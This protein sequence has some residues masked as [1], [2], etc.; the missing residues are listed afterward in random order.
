MQRRT[1][2]SIALV[3]L[4]TASPILSGLGPP[5]NDDCEAAIPIINGGHA[6][7][8]VGA[9]TDGPAHAQCEFDGQTYHDIWYLYEGLCDGLLEVHT[10]GS[11]YDTDLVGY[12]NDDCGSL[13]L[14]TCND[15]WNDC[16]VQSL[17]RFTVQEGNFYLIRVGGWNDG[18]SGDGLLFI[19]GP[20]PCPPAC[21]ADL[22]GDGVVNVGDLLTMLLAWGANP[23]HPADL[24]GDGAVT[25][26]DL[27]LLLAAWGPC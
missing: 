4:L 22:N 13:Q 17:I 8:T 6:Y 2:C 23:G 19:D 10:C 7:S 27:L 26:G 16:G 9:A 14:A 15:D 21:P 11:S 1:S 12:A 25:V 3:S 5:I 24:D 20:A 18:D